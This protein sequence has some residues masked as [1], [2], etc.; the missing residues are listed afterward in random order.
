MGDDRSIPALV[1]TGPVGAGKSTVAAAL[2]ALLEERGVRHAMIDQDR[3]RWI[4][5]N[6]PGDAFAAAFGYR[7]LAAI[8]PNYRAAGI[9]CLILADVV[10][11]RAQVAEYERAMPG[12]AVTIIRLDVPM[13]LIIR[14]LERRERPGTIDWY[15][16]R[17]PELQEIMER[18][19]VADLVIDVGER[20]P[21]EAAREIAE[22][23]GLVE[24]LT[25]GGIRP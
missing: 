15:R 22:R 1:I 16:N 5:P 13:T 20:S 12:A 21:D 9:D 7:N 3:L 19:A 25:G 6:P 14:R 11:D 8:W 2:S 24:S 4:V 23:T 18:N 10:E 17:A